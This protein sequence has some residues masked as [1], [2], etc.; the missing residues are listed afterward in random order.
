M[1]TTTTRRAAATRNLNLNLSGFR[2][3]SDLFGRHAQHTT[4]ITPLQTALRHH[5]PFTTSIIRLNSTVAS[6]SSSNLDTQPTSPKQS[7]TTDQSTQTIAASMNGT[8]NAAA[9]SKRKEPPH[10]IDGRH[11][12]HLRTNGEITPDANTPNM[13][14]TEFEEVYEE[15][16]RLPVVLPTARDSAEWQA[17]V[18]SVVR[19][20]VSIRFCQTC[21]FDTDPALTSEATGFVV[22]AERGLVVAHSLPSFYGRSLIRKNS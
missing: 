4:T 19:N 17:T 13:A 3:K 22:D 15:V 10:V 11:P 8:N 20:V 6:S 1:R 18:E 7:I 21:S 9:R 14:A 12:K 2:S 16:E 5:T